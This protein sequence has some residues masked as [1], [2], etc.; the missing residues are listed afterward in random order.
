M[1][2]ALRDVNA[3]NVEDLI[4]VAALYRPGP[5]DYIPQYAEGKRHPESIRYAHPIIEKHLSVTYG[6]MVYQEQAM[7]LARDMAGFTWQQVDK[8]RKAISKKSGKDFDDVCNLFATKSKERGIP[9]QV[10]DEVL[11]LMAKFGG[12]AFNRSHA[13]SYALL[14]YYTAYLRNYYPSE[15]LA[16]C[17]QI[18]RLDED[19][20]S[21]L[22]KECHIDKIPVKEP[23]INESGLETTVNK[24]GEI[25]LPLSTVKGVGARAEDIIKC[26]PFAD[27]NDLA[28]RARPNRMMVSALAEANALNCLSEIADFEYLEDFMEHWDNLVAER[29]R[30]EKQSLRLKKLEENNSLSIDKIVST[31]KTSAIRSTK[32]EKITKLLS[33]DLFD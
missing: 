6:I 27:L 21:I 28:T 26:Q 24:K 4:A 14:S 7:F 12:Y 5:M 16:A 23:D 30:I 32:S 9:E 29:N 8:L 15:W 25:I 11:A 33:D 20:I 3:S 1:Q 19:K 10:I 18:D 17:I 2:Q 22:R 13:C 31:N